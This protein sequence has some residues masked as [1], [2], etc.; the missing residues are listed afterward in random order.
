M[1]FSSTQREILTVGLGLIVSLLFILG[2]VNLLRYLG[3]F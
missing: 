1:K 2:V 3:V